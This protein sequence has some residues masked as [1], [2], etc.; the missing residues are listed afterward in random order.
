MLK[1]QS[2]VP[3]HYYCY[4]AGNLKIPKKTPLWSRLVGTGTDQILNEGASCQYRWLAKKLIHDF[5]HFWC[6]LVVF[7]QVTTIPHVLLL[8]WAVSNPGYIVYIIYACA[9]LQ[10]VKFYFPGQRNRYGWYGYGCAT[11][12]ANHTRSYMYLLQLKTIASCS[13]CIAC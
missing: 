9:L 10:I 7:L 12:C 4:P 3:L 13:F 1:G 8:I 11:F 6:I 5:C 2:M